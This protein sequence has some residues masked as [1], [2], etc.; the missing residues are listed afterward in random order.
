MSGTLDMVNQGIR[1]AKITVITDGF[2]RFVQRTDMGKFGWITVAV[3]GQ[4]GWSD[5]IFQGVDEMPAEL[6]AASRFQHPFVMI[7]DWKATFEK[8]EIARVDRLH[9]REVVVV[10]LT[11]GGDARCT[12]FVDRQSGRVAKME[13]AVPIPG[14]T[15]ILT[16]ETFHDWREIGSSGVQFPYRWEIDSA[17]LGKSVVQ[18]ESLETGL[19]LPDDAFAMPV[20]K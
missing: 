4:K 17:V 7:C 11:I 14:V 10:E 6:L 2:A 1:T 5:S 9:E 15:T 3:D 13:Y 16:T 8:V 18:I 20:K 19:T 12:M